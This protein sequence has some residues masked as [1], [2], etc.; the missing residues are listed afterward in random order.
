MT[1]AYQLISPAFWTRGSGT[2]LRGDAEALAIAQYLLDC[3]GAAYIGL[4]YV[5]L[6]TIA[7]H[8]GLAEDVIRAALGRIAKAGFAKYDEAAGLA[9]IPNAAELRIGAAMDPK[10]KRRGQV[11]R[12]LAAIDPKHRFARDF[13]SRY[14]V[15]YGL[16]P[17]PDDSQDA[18]SAK[19]EPPI[20]SPL[21][22]SDPSL[23]GTGLDQD[24]D[25][26]DPAP[27]PPTAT[28][29]SGPRVSSARERDDGCF[30]ETAE[31]WRE[32]I[33]AATGR[34]VASLGPLHASYLHRL[35]AAHARDEH[36]PKD[37]TGEYPRLRGDRLMLWVRRFADAYA[38]YELDDNEARW[39]FTPERATKWAD[40]GCPAP[41][42]QAR[43][44]RSS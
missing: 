38:R 41:K 44:R 4:F 5:A 18:P 31:A 33:K 36:V 17:A 15:G 37:E 9:W 3:P 26:E 22:S 20:S 10:D 30:G 6:P 13:L 43:D 42:V 29:E 19:Q 21:L 35:T 28:P 24:P 2:R 23:G 11:R 12:E 16:R 25:R 40:A 34:P 39:G 14:G 7:Y 8:T 1:T 32:G 27:P